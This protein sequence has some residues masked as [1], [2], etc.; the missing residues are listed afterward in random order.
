MSHEFELHL[1]VLEWVPLIIYMRMPGLQ[2]ITVAESGGTES[3]N[4]RYLVTINKYET[5]KED[6]EAL[7]QQYDDL[8]AARNNA[9]DELEFKQVTR[10]VRIS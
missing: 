6:Y 8:L 9:V 1:R 3:F 2:D 4:T 5:L 7:R 10:I